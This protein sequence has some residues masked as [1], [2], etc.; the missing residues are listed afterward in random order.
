LA[1]GS[2]CDSARFTTEESFITATQVTAKLTAMDQN[3]DW[4]GDHCPK[5]HISKE[6][7]ADRQRLLV[8]LVDTINEFA[9]QSANPPMKATVYHTVDELSRLTTYLKPPPSMPNEG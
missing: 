1:D 9:S 3:N 4:T 7:V 2:E 6:A 8:A 5:S